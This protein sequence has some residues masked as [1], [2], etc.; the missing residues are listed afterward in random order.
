MTKLVSIDLFIS[1]PP[2]SPKLTWLVN[3]RMLCPTF[4]HKRG[5]TFDGGICH[6]LQSKISSCKY[7]W[8]RWKHWL[9]DIINLPDSAS[10]L[11]FVCFYRNSPLFTLNLPSNKLP[12][13][14]HIPFSP[15]YLSFDTLTDVSHCHKTWNNESSSKTTSSS[16]KRK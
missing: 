8:S 7:Q 16:I 12:S 15:L 2:T 11:N 14:H 4:H 5:S 10:R 3:D 9:S 1:S 6:H 13:R